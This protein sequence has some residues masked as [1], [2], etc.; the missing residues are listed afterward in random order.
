M[1]KRHIARESPK[2]S[3]KNSKDSDEKEIDEA[4]KVVVLISF[5][6]MHFIWVIT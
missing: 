2:K 4:L 5:Y 3:K 1:T 6:L